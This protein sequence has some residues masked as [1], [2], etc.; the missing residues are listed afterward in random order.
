M[1]VKAL[2][3]EFRRIDELGLKVPELSDLDDSNLRIWKSQVRTPFLRPRISPA[4][5]NQKITD[6]WTVSGDEELFFQG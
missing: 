2:K 6:F 4:Y 5:L 3:K 1:I